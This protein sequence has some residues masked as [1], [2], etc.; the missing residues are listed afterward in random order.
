MKMQL[1]DDI[2]ILYQFQVYKKLYKGG[3]NNYSMIC[4]CLINFPTLAIYVFCLFY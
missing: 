3:E 4:M 1:S 2:S